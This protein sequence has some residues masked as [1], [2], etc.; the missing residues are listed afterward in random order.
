MP[1]RVVVRGADLREIR[2][3]PRSLGRAGRQHPALD[4]DGTRHFA[5]REAP[6]RRGPAQQSCARTLA[7]HADLMPPDVP[8]RLRFRLDSVLCADA[9][10]RHVASVGHRAGEPPQLIAVARK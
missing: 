10:G 8:G 1:V 4:G 7:P 2:H 5:A 3:P 6:D 9:C